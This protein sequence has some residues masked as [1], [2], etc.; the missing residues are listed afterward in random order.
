MGFKIPGPKGAALGSFK[1]Q[2]EAWVEAFMVGDEKASTQQ[3]MAIR[4]QPDSLQRRTALD[5]IN[6]KVRIGVKT[7][8]AP[9]PV[10]MAPA[11]AMRQAVGLLAVSRRPFAE[12]IMDAVKTGAI[13]EEAVAEIKTVCEAALVAIHRHREFRSLFSP[14]DSIG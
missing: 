4:E 3:L 2:C 6:K 5:Y 8:A 10:K 14:P 1:P 13:S 9:P 11:D 7:K 12:A